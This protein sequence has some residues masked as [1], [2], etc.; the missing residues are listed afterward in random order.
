MRN[1]VVIPDDDLRRHATTIRTSPRQRNFVAH[2]H[3]RRDPP[4]RLAV[5]AMFP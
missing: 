2:D 3:R 5:A 4:D 1:L